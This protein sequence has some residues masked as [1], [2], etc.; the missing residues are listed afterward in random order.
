MSEYIVNFGDTS[1]AFV[2]LAMAEAK[3][4]GASIGEQIVRCRDCGHYTEDEDQSYHWCGSW[5][6]QVEP[7]GFCAWG[8]RKEANYE[9]Q[10]G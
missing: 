7:D 8:E 3:S 4:H 1:S 6:E 9:R 10:D 5:C 2:G